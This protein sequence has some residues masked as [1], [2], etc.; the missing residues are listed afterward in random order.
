VIPSLGPPEA[1]LVVNWVGGEPQIK[2]W[3]VRKW[4]R[5]VDRHRHAHLVFIQGVH[6]RIGVPF[7]EL[8]T[9]RRS[10]QGEISN[11]IDIYMQHTPVA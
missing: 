10:S 6:K 8:G 3:Q 2:G 4:G 11:T 7:P 1:P 9:G 5:L